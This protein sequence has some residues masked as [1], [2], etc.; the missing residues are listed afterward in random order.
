MIWEQPGLSP[1]VAIVFSRFCSKRLW[2]AGVLAC[3]GDA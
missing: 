3:P 1:S 2:A